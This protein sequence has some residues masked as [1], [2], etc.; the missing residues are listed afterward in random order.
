MPENFEFELDE[1]V[2]AVVEGRI[3][4]RKEST[5]RGREYVVATR[6]ASGRCVYRTFS[7]DE[8]DEPEGDEPNS[9]EVIPLRA[10]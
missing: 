9:A 5:D 6:T 3:C 10:A 4:G 1:H 2:Q 7:E 8:L